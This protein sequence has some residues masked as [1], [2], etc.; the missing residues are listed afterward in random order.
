MCHAGR[1]EAGKAERIGHNCQKLFHR[2]YVCSV[3][4]FCNLKKQLLFRNEVRF[5]LKYRVN[6]GWIKAFVAT[7]CY[8]ELEMGFAGALGFDAI[9][10][11]V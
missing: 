8:L 2:P 1:E 5:H 9:P 10:L 11:T 3:D 6:Y 4:S 7:R